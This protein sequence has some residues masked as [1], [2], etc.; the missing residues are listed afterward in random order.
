MGAMI[1]AETISEKE[2]NRM[3]D[4]LW[5][6]NDPAQFWQINCD[7]DP[8]IWREAILK[9]SLANGLPLNDN[10]VDRLLN[11]T[12]GE[13]RFGAKHWNLSLFNRLY[14]QIKPFMPNSVIK[15]VRGVVHKVE[16]GLSKH[17][18]PVDA[19]Y[20]RFQWEVM[21]QLLL[22][23]GKPSLSFKNFWPEHYPYA[24]V[25]THDVESVEGQSYIPL[26]ADL[27]EKK[28][29][30]S[31]FNIVGDQIPRDLKML[32]EITARGFEIGVHG[33]H[34]NDL[35]YQSRRNFMDGAPIINECLT[36]LDAVGFR[37]PLNLRNP[38]WMQ[39]L[40]MEYDLSF[41]DTDPFEP[42]PGGTMSIWP[43]SIGHFMELPA[44]LVQ[45]NT[46]VRL[47]GEKTPRLWLDKVDF[48]KKYHGMA[49]LN[50]HPDYLIQLPVWQVYDQFLEA[51]RDRAD[52][53]NALPREV[54]RWWYRRTEGGNGKEMPDIQLI[55]CRLVDDQPVFDW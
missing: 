23:T 41:F 21:R 55:E 11:Y 33:Y 3:M 17:N 16:R 42:I 5:S 49:L 7:I 54:S 47:L 31:S 6:K 20:V 8:L 14:W 34:H 44:T 50:S 13:G 45:D 36:R 15:K 29:F 51:M 26:I 53:W 19:N 18:W 12:L 2:S 27:E 46:L 1:T 43:F 35:L 22:L 40:N 39:A 25:L 28:G 38:E 30:H 4:G 48:L 52:F 10:Q 32:R 24:L 9:S 37:S